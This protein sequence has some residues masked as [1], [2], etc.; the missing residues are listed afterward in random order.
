MTTPGPTARL[1]R[2]LSLQRHF[3]GKSRLEALLEPFVPLPADAIDFP[4]GFAMQ[5]SPASP[6]ERALYFRDAEPE[7]CAFIRDFLRPGMRF[8]DCGANLGFYTLLASRR[9]GATGHVDAFEPTAATFARLVRHIEL[10]RCGNVNAFPLALGAATGT[11]RIYRMDEENHGMNSLAGDTSAE[12]GLCEVRAFDEL[13]A[14]G[15]VQPP[16]LMKIDVEGSELG[17]LRGAEGLL[18]HTDCPTLVIELSRATMRRFGYRPEDLVDWLL[19]IRPFSIEWP[20]LG[21]LRPVDP[22]QPLPHYSALGADHGANYV[23]RP[24]RI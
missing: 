16:D 17:L 2:W 23:F 6:T 13:L 24:R 14:S 1:F 22:G 15:A 7:T 12:I 5:L 4:E 8:A 20:R 9:V 3:R 11:A 19:S 10:N 18:R 21:R